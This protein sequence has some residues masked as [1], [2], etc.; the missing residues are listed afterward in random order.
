MLPW[1]VQHWE[2]LCR[3]A[4]LG[5]QVLHR[6]DAWSAS[7]KCDSHHARNV[8]RMCDISPPPLMLGATQHLW[9]QKRLHPL[10]LRN[11]KANPQDLQN[12]VIYFLKSKAECRLGRYMEN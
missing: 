2:T 12:F 6:E 11:K 3:P 1:A 10:P 9:S 8:H 5:T 7:P 4:Q